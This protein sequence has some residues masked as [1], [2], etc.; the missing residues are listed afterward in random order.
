MSEILDRVVSWF[1]P[2]RC[3]IC[4]CVIALDQTRCKKCSSANRI[5]E[6]RCYN[7]GLGKSKCNCKS[8]N[9]KSQ[10]KKIIAPYYYDN[11]LSD[12]VHRFKFSG[13]SEL[14]NGMA[15]EMIAC[16]NKEYS[17]ISFDAVTYV[18]LSAK[19]QKAREYNQSELLAKFIADSL[20]VPLESPLYRVFDD[21]PQ[22]SKSAKQRK[23]DIFAAF[24]VAADVDVCNKTYLLVDDVKT[25]GST[26]NE[27]AATLDV[28]GAKATY[29]VTFAIRNKE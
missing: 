15:K 8:Q 20:D 3:D 19:R 1:Y 2:K 27:C 11:E 29:C 16:I 4:G 28:Y 24:D 13:Y 14:A 7:C 22:R 23:A 6:E 18:P 26:L 12:C 5:N 10:Y 9:H 17:D 25:T 21:T